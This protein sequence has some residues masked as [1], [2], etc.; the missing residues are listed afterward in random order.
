MKKE[1]YFWLNIIFNEKNWK[2]MKIQIYV[3]RN[4]SQIYN[5]KSVTEIN[6]EHNFRDY[7]RVITELKNLVFKQLILGTNTTDKHS[8]LGEKQKTNCICEERKNLNN[9]ESLR[10]F[11]VHFN[12]SCLFH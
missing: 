6:S 3:L 5:K 1:I 4:S 12:F 10:C 7:S 8:N 11:K 2:I 9:I